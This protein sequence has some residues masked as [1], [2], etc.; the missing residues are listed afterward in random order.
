M[1]KS[2]FPYIGE[3]I[4]QEL[5]AKQPDIIMDAFDLPKHNFISIHRN[6]SFVFPNSSVSFDGFSS[7]DLCIKL[8]DNS[9]FPIEVKLGSTGLQRATINK[10]LKP[11]S[12]SDHQNET[13][14]KG[15]TLSL[16]NRYFEKDLN[17]A[18][19]NDKLHA[20]IDGTYFRLRKE[21]GIIA[22]N[23]ILKSWENFPPKFNGMQKL[24]DLESLC[25][26]FGEEDFNQ[27]TNKMF[28][29]INFYN[30]WIKSNS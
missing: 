13:R 25:L 2:L 4:L 18:I 29:N 16:L 19:K 20:N 24:I 27:T 14:V 12:V 6:V 17:F 5:S 11:C 10:K 1:V 21:W 9:I 28:N 22:R 26:Q 7:I 30:T 15:N 23:H 3:S 8:N